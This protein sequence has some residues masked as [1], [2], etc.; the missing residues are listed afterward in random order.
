MTYGTSVEGIFIKDGQYLSFT[1]SGAIVLG[2]V[3]KLQED[4][5]AAV[6]SADINTVIGV[7]VGGNRQSRTST[8]DTIADGDKVTVCTRGVVNVYTDTTAIL[9]GSFVKAA[10]SGV[11]ALAAKATVGSGEAFGIALEANSSAAAT[12]QV[13]LLRG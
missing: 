10:A 1:G 2:N 12:I 11:V 6:G 7:A 8:D 4:G 3:I 13:K 5:T 9:V